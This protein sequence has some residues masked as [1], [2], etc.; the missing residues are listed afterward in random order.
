MIEKIT[1]LE[2][3]FSKEPT[4]SIIDGLMCIHLCMNISITGQQ[5]ILKALQNG[6]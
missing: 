2:K 1:D 6:R 5:D 4:Q 3:L